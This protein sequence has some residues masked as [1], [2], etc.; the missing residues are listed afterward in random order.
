MFRVGKKVRV[1]FGVG[2]RYMAIEVKWYW[3]WGL[4]TW[5]MRMGG[6]GGEGW[7]HGK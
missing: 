2:E 7:V 1:V 3:G 4:G 5:K 6:I